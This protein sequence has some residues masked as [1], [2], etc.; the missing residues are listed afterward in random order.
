MDWVFW[1]VGVGPW[2]GW[3]GSLVTIIYVY[4]W[5]N[6]FSATI[7][8]AKQF[9]RERGLHSLL[10]FIPVVLSLPVFLYN[11]VVVAAKWIGGKIGAFFGKDW[12]MG[13]VLH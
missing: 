3:M 6:G 12:Y 2:I 7:A 11:M 1:S 9:G 10:A 5:D 13:N 4:A 8:K